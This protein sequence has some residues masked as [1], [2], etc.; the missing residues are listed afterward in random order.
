MT[1]I[2]SLARALLLS[3]FSLIFAG[4]AGQQNTHGIALAPAILETSEI[5]DTGK[6]MIHTLPVGD[7]NCQVVQCPNQNKLIVMDCGSKSKGNLG[8]TKDEA[9]AYIRKM[10]NN[11]TKVVVTVSHPGRDHYNYLPTVFDGLGVRAL[12]LSRQLANYHPEFRDWVSKEQANY[13]MLVSTRAGFY[14]S[15]APDNNLSCW[16]PNGF[17][18]L[19]IDVSS[20]IVGM[21][22]GTTSSDAS[23]V[24]AMR[25]G[26]FQTM[27]TGDMTGVTE[28]AIN[29]AGPVTSLKSNV[30]TGAHHGTASEGSNSLSWANATAPQLVMFSV[31]NRFMNPRCSSADNYAP[32]LFKNVPLHLYNCGMNDAYKHRRSNDAVLVTN[33]NGLIVVSANNNGT[34]N[35][36]WSLTGL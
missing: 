6:L 17:G 9:T 1:R 3:A 10:I 11:S 7:G 19:Q 5:V 20:Y 36:S 32:Y 2:E 18:G 29:S 24:V 22:A 25:Y 28:Q 15:S 33:D 31:G 14:A 12:Y 26:S 21:N 4:C 23:M 16:R 35:F 34:F 8:W 13:E 27:F 30:I